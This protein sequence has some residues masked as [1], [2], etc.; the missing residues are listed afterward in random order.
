MNTHTYGFDPHSLG[1]QVTGYS[2]LNEVICKCPNPLHDDTNPSASF[3]IETGLLYCFSC[4]YSTNAYKLAKQ[5]GVILERKPIFINKQDSEQLWQEFTKM[6][7]AMNNPYLI[8]RGLTNL[9]IA[10]FD[11]RQTKRGVVFLFRNLRNKLTGCQMRQYD[12]R[13]KYLTFGERTCFDLRMYKHYNPNR[14]IY[15]C[16]GV[17]GMIKGY[18]SGY[19]T[20]ATIGA[21]LKES[22]LEFLKN[23]KTVYGV[24]DHDEAGLRASLKLLNI[25][26]QSKIVLGFTADTNDWNFLHSSYV[27]TGNIQD[28]ISLSSDKKRILSYGAINRTNY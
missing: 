7:L 24:F 9:D 8:K 14:P 6:P 26:P 25:I 3:N 27:T 28:I 10:E 12:A 19:Q 15:L 23:C 5:A 11:I 13:P 16:E 20:I 2:G 4:S 18:Q 1:L 21:M 17:F 22:S